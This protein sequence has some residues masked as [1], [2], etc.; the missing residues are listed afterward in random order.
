MEEAA[1]AAALVAVAEREEPRRFLVAALEARRA[2]RVKAATD[3]RVR[4]RRHLAPQ[5]LAIPR[6]RT[7][8]WNGREQRLID[9]VRDSNP[10]RS[11]ATFK[12]RA[13]APLF[14]IAPFT[15]VGK[16]TGKDSCDVWAVTPEGTIAMQASAT[17]S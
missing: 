10:G 4:W 9:L 5:E 8:A 17:F 16:P 12:M 1:T 3:G 14:D 2:A 7:Q 15:V 13:R 6:E 11:I